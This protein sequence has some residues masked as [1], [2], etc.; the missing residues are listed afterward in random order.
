MT[1]DFTSY[2]I[3]MPTSM[4][5]VFCDMYFEDGMNGVE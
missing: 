4:I 3:Q 5:D 1:A 2:I